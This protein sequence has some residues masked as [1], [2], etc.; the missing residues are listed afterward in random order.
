VVVSY[1]KENGER[2]VEKL[3]LV[4]VKESG[5]EGGFY[6]D[7]VPFLEGEKPNFVSMYEAQSVVKILELIKK[8]SEERK[9]IHVS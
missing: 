2:I 5:I 9:Y 4:D 7:L 1:T 6:R 3:T 8:S